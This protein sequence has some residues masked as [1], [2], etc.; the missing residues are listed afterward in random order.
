MIR[1]SHLP[2]VLCP[3]DIPHRLN[4]PLFCGA[5]AA[6]QLTVINNMMA[7]NNMADCTFRWRGTNWVEGPATLSPVCTS[8]RGLRWEV[9]LFPSRVTERER[10]W[11]WRGQVNKN[12]PRGDESGRL[13]R[14][15]LS[16][17]NIYNEFCKAPVSW[18]HRYM[19]R[20]C[21]SSS[22]ACLFLEEAF[23]FSCFMHSRQ[24]GRCRTPWKCWTQLYVQF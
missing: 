15:Y 5:A 20:R 2:V 3:L 24:P 9:A 16:D 6:V 14:S 1:I 7:V 23:G 17:Y 10:G 18:I 11:E 13:L 21:D 19:V 22:C 4:F 12:K 8:C